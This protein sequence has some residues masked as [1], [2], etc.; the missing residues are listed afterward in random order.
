[1]EGCKV[2]WDMW[3]RVEGMPG[4]A[5]GSPGKLCGDLGTYKV[6]LTGEQEMSRYERLWFRREKE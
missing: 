4:S 1:M 3:K 6:V 5:R 2:L